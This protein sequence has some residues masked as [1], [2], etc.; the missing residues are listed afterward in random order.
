LRRSLRATLAGSVLVAAAL[1]VLCVPIVH[2]LYGH[3]YGDAA[4]LLAVLA[5]RLPFLGMGAPLNGALVARG[6]QLELMRNTVA[7]ALLSALLVVAAAATGSAI[8]VAAVSVVSMAFLFVLNARTAR[9]LGVLS[10]VR[11]ALGLGRA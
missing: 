7:A 10:S 3:R 5:L 2:L 4:A 8:V 6:H 1:A 9:R 11:D